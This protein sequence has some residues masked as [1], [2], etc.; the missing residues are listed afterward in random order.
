M[1][2]TILALQRKWSFYRLAALHRDR[3]EQ[4]GHTCGLEVSKLNRRKLIE[5]FEKPSIVEVKVIRFSAVDAMTKSRLLD[6]KR[7][8]EKD[9]D[10]QV[11]EVVLAHFRADTLRTS[12]EM[13]GACSV[14]MAAI[15]DQVVI[16]QTRDDFAPAVAVV[17]PADATTNVSPT[18]TATS[19]A[20]A[21]TATAAGAATTTCSI[22]P[23]AMSNVVAPAATTT[24]TS[25]APAATATEVAA[26]TTAN[27]VERA[28][29][30]TVIAPADTTR[31][32]VPP[33]IC[34]GETLAFCHD[35]FVTGDPRGLCES[36]VLH[37]V[38]RS[39]RHGRAISRRYG[40]VDP[41]EQLVFLESEYVLHLD[42]M[43]KRVKDADGNAV[44]D[45][46]WLNARV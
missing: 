15:L 23:A 32:I 12:H 34:A 37:I 35:M 17:N 42:Q 9:G 19:V 46:D 18:A 33:T 36:K 26:V 21:A 39:Y 4:F 31:T 38:D 7:I 13:D 25:V 16:D 11:T 40:I 6:W 44:Q 14:V 27:S 10:R 29:T 22:K 3:E 41:D 30:S 2:P 8:W 45:I 24:T 1:G 5:A 28:A 20:P 43:V